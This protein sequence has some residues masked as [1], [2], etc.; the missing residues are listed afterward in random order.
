MNRIT[1]LIFAFIFFGG[2]NVFGQKID[3]SDLIGKWNVKNL[4][5]TIEIPNAQKEMIDALKKAFMESTFEF[6]SDHNFTLE[7]DFIGIEDMMTKVHWNYIK[8]KSR[9]VIQEWADKDKINSGLMDIIVEKKN[10]K[11]FFKLTESPLILEVEK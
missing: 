9:I 3:E 8:E 6:E 7:I 10:G 2:S 1:I 4:E 5:G 11:V